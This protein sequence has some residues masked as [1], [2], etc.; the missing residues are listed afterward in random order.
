MKKIIYFLFA[1]SLLVFTGCENDDDT[2]LVDTVDPDPDQEQVDDTPPFDGDNNVYS[3]GARSNPSISGVANMIENEDGSTLVTLKLS[4]TTSGNSHPSHIHFNSAAE[5]GAIA[6]TLNDVDGETGISETIV[7]T[8]DDGTAI[9]F[10]QLL[11]FDGYINTHLSLER[12]DVLIAQGDIGTNELT[13]V[14]KEYLLCERDIEGIKG[15]ALFAERVNGTALV[16]IALINDNTGESHPSHIHFNSAAEGGAIAASLTNV[17]D[18]ISRTSV[19]TLD[20]GTA[21]TYNELLDFDGYIN[22]HLSAERLDLLVAQGDIGSNELNG[23][24]KSYELFTRDIEGVSGTALFQERVNGTALVTIALE[25]DN[26]GESHP[27]HIHMN[28]AAEGGPILYTFNNVEDGISENSVETLDDG[29]AITYNELLDFDGYIN[30]HLSAERLDLLVAQG[31]IGSNELN[32]N[33]KSY[34]LFTRDIEGVSGTALFQ[35]RVNGTALVTI[36]LEND[37]T[38]ESHP[39]HIHMN[40]AAEGG[41]ILYTFNNVEDGI[42]ENSVETLDDGTAITYNELLDFDGYINVHLSAERLDLLVAQGDIG[43]N[44]L[45]GNSKSY[46]LFT[47]DIEGV[48]GTALFQERVNGTA[49]VTIALENDNTGESHPSHIHM[50]SAAEGGPILYTFNNVEDGIS[51]NSVETLDD[52]TA[53]T[54]NE[55]LDFDGYIN[56]HLSAERLDLLVA[57]G[58]IGQNELTGES[59]TYDLG[60]VSDPQIS[61]TATFSQRVN[62]ETLVEIA[63]SGTTEGGIH[64][65]HIHMGAAPGP[66]PIIVSLSPVI[67]ANGLSATNVTMLSDG[68]TLNYSDMLNIDGYINVHLSSEQ[69]EVLIAQ[70]NVGANAQ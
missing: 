59:I 34:E 8:L 61:G 51:E 46:E 64:P 44:E 40:S 42:S 22:V 38:G 17:E 50:N 12:L 10:E 2:V 6:V 60:S 47:R 62:N 21:I 7:S 23:N 32:G 45:N 16:T 54:Y 66:G 25:N 39:S 41:P 29:T 63:L 27:S 56:V 1:M 4:G 53:I 55:L 5:G 30:V 9:S 49:L 69:L 19:E 67:G 36:A 35:E 65:A 48:S 37:N 28:S 11:Q 15:T 33:S 43:S 57:Q 58:D 70:G 13:G 20:D 3:L 18:G 26:T 31:D 24:S 68:T 52:G 14:T